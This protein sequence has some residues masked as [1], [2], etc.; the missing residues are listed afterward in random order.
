MAKK[1][2]KF[3]EN[4]LSSLL[5]VFIGFG[6][7]LLVKQ[8]LAFG[9]SS[10]MPVVAVLSTSMQH[11]NP[12]HTHYGWLGSE[13]GYD[14]DT[15][16]SWPVPTGFAV[17]DMPIITGDSEYN[18]GDVIVYTIPCN[19]Y[20]SNCDVPIIHRIIKVNEDGTYQTKGDNNINQLPYEFN[21]SEQQIHGKVLLVIPKMGYFKVFMA[22]SLGMV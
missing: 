13:L 16:E 12:E 10:D 17:G 15:I 21:V 1:G 20:P 18:V 14:K 19:R 4:I 22:K 9:L 6:L 2:E 11:E 3:R 7:A 8:T 5:Y